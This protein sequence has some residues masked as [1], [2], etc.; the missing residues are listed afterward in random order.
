[1][2]HRWQIEVDFMTHPSNGSILRI[3]EM[4]KAAVLQL[5]PEL[6]LEYLHTVWR[7]VESQT[8]TPLF[9]E[10]EI[11]MGDALAARRD[12]AASYHYEQAIE[13]CERLREPEPKLKMI[14]HEHFG[15]H[16][17]LGG[18]LSVAR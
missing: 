15:N 10:Y 18:M 2:Y 9:V 8:E 11:L 16:L 12:E 1:M 17:R 3:L 5:K 7:D 4:A 14:A 6:A 13:G